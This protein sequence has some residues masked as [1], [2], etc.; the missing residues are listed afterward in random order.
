MFIDPNFWPRVHGGTTHF[1]LALSIVAALFE[2]VTFV[3]PGRFAQR[4]RLQAAGYFAILTAACGT[5]PAVL[6]GLFMTKGE[7]MGHDLE[8]LHHLFIWPAFA[9]I[10][11]LAVWRLIAGDGAGRKWMGVY[12]ATLCITA[13]L[14]ATAGY[15]GGEMLMHG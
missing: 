10:I 7:T 8:R 9:L 5:F 2:S 15:W 13:M 11:G 3:L 4:Q 12:V 14:M 6:S 1:P